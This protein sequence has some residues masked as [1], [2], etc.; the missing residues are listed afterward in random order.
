MFNLLVCT[1]L[2]SIDFWYC[3][4][5]VYSRFTLV[6]FY[7]SEFL[8]LWTIFLLSCDRNY[9]VQV[10][11]EFGITSASASLAS[12]LTGHYADLSTDKCSSNVVEKCLIF[13]SQEDRNKIVRELLQVPQFEQLLQHPYANY[14]IQAALVNTEVHIT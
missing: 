11:L 13:F 6:I 1:I 3:H 10:A 4:L 12:Q 8:R 9:V 2:S 5:L 7:N 14:V